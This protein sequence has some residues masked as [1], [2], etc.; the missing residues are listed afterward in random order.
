MKRKF[1]YRYRVLIF[2]FFLTLITYLDRICI[3]LVGVRIKSEF[4]LTNEQFGWVL[5]SF[6]LAYAIFE[7]PS[8]VLG[9]RIGQRAVLIRI[10]LWWSIFT[11]LTGVTTGLFTLMLV[12][13]LFGM[14]ESGAYPTSSAVISRWFPAG[15]TAR[16]M[17]SLFVGQNAGAA[18]APLIVIPIAI[19]Y[20]WR[21][22]FFVNGFIGLIWVLVC[23]L[24]FRN[25]PSEKKGVTNEE[26]NFIESNRRFREHK[27]GFSWKTALKSRS[28]QAL[29]AASFCSQWAQ[30]FFIAWMPV[31][32]QEGRHFSE[33]N[34]KI[35]T[36]YFFIIGIAGVLIAGFLSDWLVKR[37]G[38]RFGRRFLGMVSLSLLALTFLITAL[39]SNNTV[40]VIS[41]YMSQLFYSFNPLVSFS[42]CV[43]IGGNRVGTVAGIMNFFGQAGAFFLAIVFGKIA[44]I[45]HSFNIPLL[46]VAGVLFVGSML[47]FFVDASRPIA[48]ETTNNTI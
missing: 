38:V 36:S 14:G 21:A 30:Y 37:K 18:I 32:L 29:V 2:L 39:T 13:F 40:V 43:D 20:G 35:I 5:G 25:N 23:F 48:A 22:S 34:M 3:S 12:R 16:S 15:E 17:S 47:W 28:L 41:L 42:T 44:D 7:I 8:G 6:A 45:T 27:Q 31:Y 9:D 11:A 33:N 24:W 46:V 19:A 26:K 10:V 4:N 1:S